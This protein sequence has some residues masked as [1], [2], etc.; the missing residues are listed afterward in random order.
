M[1][2]DFHCAGGYAQLSAYLLIGQTPSYQDDSLSLPW[3]QD[4]I[5]QSCHTLFAG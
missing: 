4:G 1:Q 2:G 3:R 5:L